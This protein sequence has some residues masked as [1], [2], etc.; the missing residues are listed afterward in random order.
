[1]EYAL[2]RHS[3][4]QGPS[5]PPKDRSNCKRPSLSN[6]PDNWRDN[7][8]HASNDY[9]RPALAAMS[10][11]GCRP[12]EVKGIKVRQDDERVMFEIKGAK[13]DED[14]GIK[15]RCISIE[16]SELSQ[17]QAGRDLQDWLGNRERRT[18]AHR[19]SVEAFRGRVARAADRAGHDD[20]TSY[21]YRHAE[22]REL[23]NSDISKDEIANRLGHRSE[24]SQSVY[25]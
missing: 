18:I 4:F 10:L 12:A 25:G 21:S 20:V 9:D 7:V 11:T 24:R 2:E 3:A 15:T 17:S 13:V 16:K 5:R 6:L 19:G 1:M 23:K 8:Q 22:A 14:R